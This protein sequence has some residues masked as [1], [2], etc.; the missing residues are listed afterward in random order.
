VAAAFKVGERVNV[1]G[2][3]KGRGF[4]GVVKRWGFKGGKAT[5]GSMFH[6]APGSIGSSAWPSRVVKGRRMA[7]HYGQEKVTIKNMEVI[8]IR[9]DENIMIVKGAVPGYKTGIVEVLKPKTAL[10]KK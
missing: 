9:P 4:S 8:D 5:H 1:S 10:R 2:L 7:G 3:T 6:R